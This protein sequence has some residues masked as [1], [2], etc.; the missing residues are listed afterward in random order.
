MF[1]RNISSI[2]DQ[3]SAENMSKQRHLINL[4]NTRIGLSSDCRQGN[5]ISLASD[6]EGLS[7]KR[8]TTSDNVVIE[9]TEAMPRQNSKT[10]Q[11]DITFSG[12]M[13]AA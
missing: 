5:E 3:C 10:S 11:F 12:Q 6:G 8:E 4:G 9:P 1:G 13:H 7:L 2:P